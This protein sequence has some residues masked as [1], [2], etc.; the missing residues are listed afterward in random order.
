[1]LNVAVTNKVV[2]QDGLA[3]SRAMLNE[4]LAAKFLTSSRGLLDSPDASG[5][6]KSEEAQ[7]VA[8]GAIS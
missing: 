7:L 2:I 5:N 6:S 4:C 1:M 3:A 8:G